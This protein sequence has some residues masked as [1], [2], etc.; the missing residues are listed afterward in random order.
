MIRDKI[1]NWSA[2][3]DWRAL[4]SWRPYFLIALIGF[5][6]YSQTLFFDFTYFDDGT[7]VVENQEILGNIKNVGRIFA[8]D[9]FFSAPGAKFYYRPL[10]NV[11]LMVDSQLGLIDSKIGTLPFFFHF[12]N[13]IFHLLAAALVFYLLN[14]LLKKRSLAFILSLFFL[15]HPALAPAVAW[16]PG[17]N[18]SFLAIFILTAFM[19]FLNFL[20]RP[21]LRTYLGFLALF[22]CALLT[23][24]SAIGLPLVIIFYFWFIDKGRI[25]LPDKL[26]LIFGSGAVIFIWLIMRRLAFGFGQSGH[27]ASLADIWYNLPALFIF[28]GKI[29]LPF[30]LSVLPT[31][32]D[33]RFIWGILGL[34]G[35]LALSLI[36]PP[37]S[38]KR[39]WFG[40]FWLGIFLFPT[41]LNPDTSSSF[42]SHRLYLPF[43]GFL[44]ILGEFTWSEPPVFGRRRYFFIISGI[45][46]G[47]AILTICHS[48]S[49][50]NRLVFWREAVID[51]PNASLAQRNLGAMYYL[52]GQPILAERYYRQAL[53]LNPQEP[54]AHNNLGVIYLDQKKYLQA[55]A[56]F[57]RELEVNPGYEKAIN[58][59][60]LTQ[61]RLKPESVVDK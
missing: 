31:L 36:F 22:G 45:L 38:L 35:L 27:L 28:A 52:E 46:V 3:E 4:K 17:R 59:L 25:V 16:I 60:I 20:E 26:L 24:E 18:D 30:D 53:K 23:K 55:Q 49:F 34:A 1:Q 15:V 7:L 13:I 12:S 6:L 37:R 54:M 56:E 5:L 19:I 11:S 43:F 9:A 40:L 39:F 57:Y 50:R 61:S 42:L 10:L 58:N 21:R 2:R 29:I 33:A 41:F 32:T 47:L 44:L 14:R 48:L 51:S 8:S